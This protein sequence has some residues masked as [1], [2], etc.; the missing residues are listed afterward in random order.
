MRHAGVN[1]S[2]ADRVVEMWTMGVK[3]GDVTGHRSDSDP[4]G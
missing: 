1:V 2:N 4:D 3:P